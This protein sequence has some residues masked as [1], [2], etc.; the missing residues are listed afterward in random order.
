MQSFKMLSNLSL[1]KIIHTDIFT[2]FVYLIIFLI[3]LNISHLFI[4]RLTDGINEYKQDAEFQK[5]VDTIKHVL[6]STMDFILFILV[7]MFALTKIG[8]DIRPILT[9]AGVLGVAVGF[10]AKRFVEDIITGLIILFEGQIRVGDIVEINGK[11]GSVERFNLKMV[12]LRD[13][14]GYVHYIRNGMIDVVSNLTR[15]YSYYSLD[16]AVSYSQNLEQIIS[17]L[18]DIYNNQLSQNKELSQ[19]ILAPLEILGV[20]KFTDNSLIIKLRIKTTPTRQWAVGRE[21]NKLIKNKFDELNIQ[22][23]TN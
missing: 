10:G 19:D 20:D 9:A 13:I 11:T 8:V 15:D 22:F 4:D 14:N 18:N 3:L 23:P 6:R 12:V 5:Q 16:L 2:I 7:L 17:A 21:F 1:E